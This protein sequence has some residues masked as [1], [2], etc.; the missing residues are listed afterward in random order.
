MS[1]GYDITV[2][3]RLIAEIWRHSIIIKYCWGKKHRGQRIK[4]KVKKS[5][6]LAILPDLIEKVDVFIHR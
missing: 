6:V 1:I 5:I 2:I 3:T 4:R